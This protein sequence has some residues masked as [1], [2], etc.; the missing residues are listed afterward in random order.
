MP[1]IKLD[2]TDCQL[3]HHIQSNAKI[4]NT[5]LA[6][7]LGLSPSPCLR[8]VKT[9]EKNGVIKRYVGIIDPILVGLPISVFITVSLRNQGR[10]ALEEFESY[11]SSYE[12]IMECY[13]M[14]GSSD[15]LLR[16]IM[17]DMESYEQFLLDKITTIPCVDNIESSFSLKQVL[18]R[19]EMPITPTAKHDRTESI[20]S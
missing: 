9:L 12:E 4:A 16:V 20:D 5:E 6:D 15:Y 17:P 7:K 18:Y 2:K 3:L 19:T 13:L 1:K 8:R 14:T 10:D 11:I